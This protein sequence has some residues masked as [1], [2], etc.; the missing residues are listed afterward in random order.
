MNK[1]VVIIIVAL[2]AMYWLVFRNRENITD[3]KS[4][5][6]LGIGYRGGTTVERGTL[7]ER[8][9]TKTRK[10]NATVNGIVPERQKAIHPN[11]T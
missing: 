5:G 10:S 1:T 7:Q 3:N 8:G 2:A 4:G 11:L 6:L 9:G